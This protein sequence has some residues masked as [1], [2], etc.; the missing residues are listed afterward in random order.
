MIRLDSFWAVI[1]LRISILKHLLPVFVAALC[2]LPNTLH[3]AKKTIN[4]LILPF[5]IHAA[6]DLMYLQADIPKALRGHLEP[7]GA[8]ILDFPEQY[9]PPLKDLDI[10]DSAA[11]RAGMQSGAD[12]VIWGS[13][14]WI[15]Q[16]FSLDVRLLDIFKGETPDVF[17]AGGRGLENLPVKVAEL[18]DDIILDIFELVTIAEITVEGTERIEVDAVKKL[19]KTQPGDIYSVKSLSEDLKSVFAM[20]FFDDV[21]IE[22]EEGPEGRK[23]IF[24]VKEKPTIRYINVKG[25]KPA[26]DEDEI[27][28]NL[29]IKTGSILNINQIQ[30][31]IQRIEDLYKEKNYHNVKVAYSVTNTSNNQADLKFEIEEG[32]KVKIIDITFTGNTT[33]SEKRLKKVMKTSE[34][35]FLHWI[36]QTGELNKEDLNQDAGALEAYYHNNGFIRAKVGEPLVEFKEDGIYVTIKINEG[37]RFKVGSFDIDGDLIFPKELL[38]EKSNLRKEE[39]YNRTTLRNDLIAISD[40]YSD[41]GYAYVDI[42]PLVK[43]N[44]EQLLVDITYQI[45]KR[46]Q[47][48]VEEIIIAGNTRTRDKVIRRQIE[49]AEQGLF[50]GSKLKRSIR[51]LHRLDYFEDVKVNTVKGN[52]PDQMVLK[53]DVVEKSTGQISFG[54]G[55]SNNEGLFVVGSVAE[56]NLFGRGWIADVKG[57]LGSE[58]TR[59]SI[60]FTEPWLFDIPLTAGGRLYNWDKE[61]DAYERKSRGGSIFFGYPIFRDTRINVAFNT[62]IAK[63]DVKEPD[64]VP[65]SIQDL[66]DIFGNGNIIT[67]SISTGLR[68]DTRDRIFSPTQGSRH[69]FTVTYAGLGGDIGYTKLAGTLSHYFPLPWRFVFFARGRAGYVYENSGFILPDY[70]KF[71]LGGMNTIRGYDQD[72]IQPRDEDGNVIGGDRFVQANF[73]VSHPLYEPAGIDGVIFL[74]NAAV[75]DPAAGDPAQQTINSESMRHSAGVEIRWNSPMGPLRFAYAWKLDPKEGEDPSGFEFSMGAAF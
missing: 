27:K 38:I 56:R 50:R 9:T 44:E 18:A 40:M 73:E 3:A 36:M 41:E 62:D 34:K 23:I 11:R 1:F 67:N 55:Y 35:G 66:V 60:G 17:T 32:E 2:F 8:V 70:E 42:A 30:N 26:Y 20:G 52:E 39:F 69:N 49:L 48:Y 61:F 51:N 16:R 14:T 13:M 68:Y 4:V 24:K 7:E 22:A 64:N 37:P 6:E 58:T 33:I 43:E 10:D 57:E 21:L 47:V 53:I 31:N 54:G 45:D 71:Y 29:T 74:D 46:Q 15:G 25:A 75:A 59:F 28:E 72:E 63:I 5:E 19:I 12:M 65:Q